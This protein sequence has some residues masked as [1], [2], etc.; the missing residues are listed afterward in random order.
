[1]FKALHK[2]SGIVYDV[3]QISDLHKDDFTFLIY[4][5]KKWTKVSSSEF[6]PYV[7]KKKKLYESNHKDK[8][9]KFEDGM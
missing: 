9:Y 5:D 4:R 7:D 8:E 3:Y 6:E 2:E 1:M